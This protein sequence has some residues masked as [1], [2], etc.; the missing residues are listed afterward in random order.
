[1]SERRIPFSGEIG[2]GRQS[3]GRGPGWA[4]QVSCAGERRLDGDAI[5][6]LENEDMVVI[7]RRKR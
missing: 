6:E 3:F 2:C 5:R 4:E 7:V 1:M